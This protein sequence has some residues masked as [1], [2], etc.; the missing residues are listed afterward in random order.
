M[1]LFCAKRY[2]GTS[3]ADLTK[4]LGIRRPSS[5]AVFGAQKP[6]AQKFGTYNEARANDGN[7]K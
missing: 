5:Y 4:T 1:H 3:V 2:E 7:L 6:V